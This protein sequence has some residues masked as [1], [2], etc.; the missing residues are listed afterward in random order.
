MVIIC[1]SRMKYYRYSDGQ[2]EY[3]QPRMHFICTT[4]NRFEPG[5]RNLFSKIIIKFLHAN[6]Q[7]FNMKIHPVSLHKIKKMRKKFLLWVGDNL[8]LRVIGSCNIVLF[9]RKTCETSQ[10][11]I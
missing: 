9:L 10:S 3:F 4:F 7:F 5:G 1:D 2:C 11:K 6:V 8:L